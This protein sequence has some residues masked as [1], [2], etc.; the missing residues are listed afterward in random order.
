MS[1]KTLAM[2]LGG[3]LACA[4]LVAGYVGRFLPGRPLPAVQGTLEP[5]NAP[6]KSGEPPVAAPKQPEA[7]QAAL[8][9]GTNPA[10]P[11]AAKPVPQFDVVRVEPSGETVVAGRGQPGAKVALLSGGKVL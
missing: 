7:G 9:P 6:G 5:G 8:T 2:L 4:V 3:C 1:S 10:P 11:A